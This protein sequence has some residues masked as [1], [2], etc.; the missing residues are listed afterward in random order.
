MRVRWCALKAFG[1][2]LTQQQAQRPLITNIGYTST[3]LHNEQYKPWCLD[4]NYGPLGKESFG[5]ALSRFE[6]AR[7]QTFPFVTTKNGGKTIRKLR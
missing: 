3:T 2:S 6:R 5:K 4:N 7:P 1:S